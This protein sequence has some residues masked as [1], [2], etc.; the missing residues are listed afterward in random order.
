MDRDKG[1]RHMDSDDSG[2]LGVETRVE[3]VGEY[4]DVAMI[5]EGPSGSTQHLEPVV[6]DMSR[7]LDIVDRTGGATKSHIVDELPADVVA[8]LD[9]EAVIHVLR[10][11]E[12]Y[13]LV[14]LD[15]NTWRPGPTLSTG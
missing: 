14:A 5:L 4:E 10:T 6:Q 15:G 3:L 9:A 8:D 7:V 1:F 2:E 11:L 12:L 13:D